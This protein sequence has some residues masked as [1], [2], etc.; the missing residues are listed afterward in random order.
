[1]GNKKKNQIINEVQTNEII[2]EENKEQ[3]KYNEKIIQSK[4]QENNKEELNKY[5]K[6]T[7]ELNQYDTKPKKELN[8][9]ENKE[10]KETKEDEKQFKKV[11]VTYKKA[12]KR[13]FGVIIAILIIILLA[14]AFSVVFAI[15]NMNNNKILDGISIL[16]IDVSDLTTEEATNQ[17]SSAI[18]ERF[19]G[20]NSNLILK[21]EDSETIVTADTFNAKF[22]V[23]QAVMEAYNIGRS[24]NI[25][26]N[27][28][29]ILQTMIFKKDIPAKLHL[30]EEL[31]NK[32]I[33]DI[34]SK[35]KDAV[36]E[37]SYYIEDDTLTIVS[38]KDGYVIDGENLKEQIYTQLSDIHNNYQIINIPVI[39]KKPEPIN[40]EKIRSEIYKEP[41]DAYVEKNPTRVHT[42]VNGVDFGISIEEAKKLVSETKEE[43]NIPLK[44]TKPKKTIENLGEE[45]FPDL[46]A[47]FSTIYDAS[48][49]NRSTNI[50]LASKKVNGTIIMP[51]EN[52]SFNTVVG[53]RTIEAGFKEGTAYIGGEV[54]PD[55][56]GGICQLS[57]T[58]YNV[59]LL[60][61]L[62]IVERSNHIFLTGYVAASRDATV[63][64]GSLDFIF[65]NS[66]SYPIKIVTS[67]KNGVCKVSMY[68]IKEETEYEV[69]I[70]S[71][72][73]SYIN[74]TTTYENDPT[75]LEGKE[76]VKQSGSSG[77]RSEGYRI[78]KL[79]GK[80]VSQELLSKD[81]YSAMKKIVRK[82]TK[83]ATTPTPTTNTQTTNTTKPATN[84]TTQTSK[85]STNTTTQTTKPSTSTT[86]QTSKPS[87]STTTQTSKN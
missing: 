15:L 66:R 71:K 10:T 79:N 52:F 18:E 49:R 50:E 11:D 3:E 51:G 54:V 17:I 28:Y 36:V 7:K 47:T 64:Y 62:E 32:T 81:T 60:A 61:N 65:K 84:T 75:L 45:A 72:I 14:M 83:K 56:G 76:V 53:K 2:S 68:G 4:P 43:Y 26:T 63:Y 22:D 73:T 12:G 78:L 69:I 19:T 5:Q 38:G 87:T 33:T 13:K 31:V 67:S 16:G 1:M 27:N 39:S 9:Y 40:V 29:A 55:V 41:K 20:E 8:N 80:V 85:P 44:Y 58:I 74:P 42:H 35:M 37:S 86:T 24:G 77:C 23:E 82:G 59:A 70:Q 6:P 57:S 25:I 46:L 21:R 30:N 48:N 34:N